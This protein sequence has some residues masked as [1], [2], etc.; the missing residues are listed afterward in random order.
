MTHQV[1]ALRCRNATIDA[2]RLFA[3]FGVVLLHADFAKATYGNADFAIKL[4]FRWCVPFFF[5]TLGYFL[6]GDDKGPLVSGN[7]IR[8]IA[9]I[10]ALA[11]LLYLPAATVFAPDR[12]VLK[13]LLFSG[14]WFHLW[15]LNA[16]L[17]GFC[18]LPLLRRLGLWPSA[19][20]SICLLLAV[21]GADVVSTLRGSPV[22]GYYLLRFLQAAPLIF[23]GYWL[24]RLVPIR[25]SRQYGEALVLG[26]LTLL[27]GQTI[28][29]RHWSDFT[30]QFPL[31]A[32]PVAVGL[33]LLARG[34]QTPSLERLAQVGA[35]YALPIY[36]YHPVF[37]TV[38]E[39][40]SLKC[41]LDAGVVAPLQVI[42]GGLATLLFAMLVQR[43]LPTVAETMAGRLGRGGTTSQRH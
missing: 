11:N 21:H 16:L 13:T 19:I 29:S 1:K 22:Q 9:L 33:V 40:V 26:G 14:T 17:A 15:F 6:P 35:L 8:R 38:V 39:R 32:V 12:L 34:T 27:A 37:L 42:L 36:I 25:S 10:A 31:G 28:F 3:A 5:L 7:R 43:T 20:F 2:I 24:G 41:G 30:P 23:L 18:L 4:V